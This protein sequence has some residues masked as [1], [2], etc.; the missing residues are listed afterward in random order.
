MEFPYAK[1]EVLRAPRA[2]HFV[3]ATLLV[4]FLV[5][6]IPASG[7]WLLMRPDLPQ[8]VLLYW[9]IHQPR[10]AG[11]IAA[12]ILG[13]AMDV[14]DASVLGQHPLTYAVAVYLAL[15]LRVRVLTFK[16]WQQ[17]LH[18]LAI[19]WASQAVMAIVNAFVAAVFPG[20]LYFLSG[21]LG[22]ILWVPISQAVEYVSRTRAS[23]AS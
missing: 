2:A 22:A 4:A 7:P 5:Y 14:A 13:I 21:V 1:P 15:V 17:A 9:T 3:F 23:E 6:L 10:S 19:L 18:V 20:V 12:F 11:F 8:V 16:L